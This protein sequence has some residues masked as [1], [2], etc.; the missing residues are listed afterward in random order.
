MSLAKLPARWRALACKSFLLVLGLCAVSASIEHFLELREAAQLTASD[1]FYNAQGRRI[2][3]HLTGQG[4]PG[5]TVVLLDGL[6]AILEQWEGVQTAL[7][8]VSPV[9]SYDRG[10]TSTAP[11]RMPTNSL[12]S[13][14]PQT[15][16]GRSCSSASP[17]AP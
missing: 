8:T 14:T 16:P 5:P 13:Y 7:S 1:T 15:S 2:R 10:G 12:N 3:Y 4:N 9:L 6:T 11:T 17:A